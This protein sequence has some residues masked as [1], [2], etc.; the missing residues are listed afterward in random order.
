MHCQRERKIAKTMN[1][2][3]KQK[4]FSIYGQLLSYRRLDEAW[5]HVKAN[6]GA[7]GVDKVSIKEFDKHS[8]QYLN[9]ILNELKTKIY[10]P[11]SARR[12]YIKKKNGKLRPLGIPTIKDRIIQQALVDIL[13]PFFEANVFHDNSCGFRPNRG[14]E[15][16]LKKVV[17]RLEYGYYY[18]YDFDI[19]GC[20]DNIPH[21]KLMKVLS[22]YISDGTV[23]NMMWQWLKAGYMEDNKQFDSKSGVQQ[24]G[25][26]SPLAT[27]IYLN[28]LD[29]ELSKAGI[30]LIRY[31]DDGIAMC[32]SPKELEK[33]VTLVNN[34][35]EKLGLELSEE[36]THVVD[37][38]TESF[39][40]L[41]YIFYP[42]NT[43]KNGKEYYRFGP[44]KN[45]Q[46]KFKQ[47]LKAMT[48]KTFSL[49]FEDWTFKLNPVMRGKYNYMLATVK[50]WQELKPLLEARGIKMK[51]LPVKGIYPTLDGY[52]RG[53]LRVNFSNRGRSKHGGQAAGKKLTVKYNNFFFV[54]KM[55]LTTGDY[56]IRKL[57]FGKDYTPED[58]IRFR[59]VK[60][61]MTK[62]KSDPKKKAFF[63]MA[64]AK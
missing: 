20:F 21:K 53:R 13:S 18:I 33:A 61:S 32:K 42:L 26:W 44:S 39:E 52:V 23:L 59:E 36:K 54:C 63:K 29:W 45:A 35:L 19:K 15:L 5:K 7:G 31:A 55:K 17:C 14:T 49:S 62:R 60:K 4:L 56:M 28:E 34:T 41:N 48:C 64:Y 3:L 43:D 50:V 25:V 6:H 10:K 8:E 11:T 30:Q 1:E 46:K 24:G 12:V 37:F 9:E 47:D 2:P 57:I 27:N 58:Y 22:K 51:G 38:H 16:A 40:Y